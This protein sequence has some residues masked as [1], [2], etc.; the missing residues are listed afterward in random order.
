MNDETG[1]PLTPSQTVGPYFTL[2]L[3][4][5]KHESGFGQLITNEI[6][7][8]GEPI[9]IH[10]KV[11]DGAGEPVNDAMLEIIQADGNGRLDAPEFTGFARAGTGDAADN[12]YRFKTIKPGPLGKCEAPYICMIVFM[13]GMLL[14]TFTRIYFAD[15][16][17]NANDPVFSRLPEDRRDSLLAR[18]VES[19]DAVSYEFNVHMQ[20]D[21]ETVFFKLPHPI[22]D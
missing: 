22:A 7:G 8:E 3:T 16:A 14:H 10:G 2:G 11:F 6:R 13:R 17:A 21:R 1:P 18:R 4:P 15:E 9:T 5:E 19:A 20:G 12:S